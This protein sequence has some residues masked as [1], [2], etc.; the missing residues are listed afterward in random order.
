VGFVA[1]LTGWPVQGSVMW[2]VRAFP[3]YVT[4][5]LHIQRS[6]CAAQEVD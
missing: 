4:A 6:K 1:I 5:S 2:A 3:E